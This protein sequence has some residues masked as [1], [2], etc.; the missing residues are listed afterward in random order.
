MGKPSTKPSAFTLLLSSVVPCIAA[1]L[2]RTSIVVVFVVAPTTADRL[3]DCVRSRTLHPQRIVLRT[4]D[5]YSRVS[6]RLPSLSGKSIFFTKC[7]DDI[8][9]SLGFRNR[10]LRE[11]QRK[12]ECTQD[13]WCT[14]PPPYSYCWLNCRNARRLILDDADTDRF[15]SVFDEGELE[16]AANAC[17]AAEALTTP[18]LGDPTKIGVKHFL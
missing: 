18:C 15:L 17:L 3:F 6:D 2:H 12:L 1:V 10:N 14:N 11:T 8:A 7:I 5:L 16:D 4:H 9:G 13:H